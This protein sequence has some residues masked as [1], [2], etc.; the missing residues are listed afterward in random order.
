MMVPG[1]FDN[2]AA[3]ASSLGRVQFAMSP[4][5]T[6]VTVAVCPKTG[7]AI[8]TAVTHESATNTAYLAGRLHVST[9]LNWFKIAISLAHSPYDDCILHHYLLLLASGVN[10]SLWCC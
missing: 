5:P 9:V 3:V 6:S 8:S 4:A 7:M 10:Y 2:R 1:M